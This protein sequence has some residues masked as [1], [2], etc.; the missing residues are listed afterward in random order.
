MFQRWRYTWIGA[1]PIFAENLQSFEQALAPFGLRRGV[2]QPAYG[3]AEAVV[4]VSCNQPATPYRVLAL[5]GSRLREYGHVRVVDANEPGAITLVAN[6]KP[7][8]GAEVCIRQPDGSP[9]DPDQQGHV[10][11][12]GPFVAQSYLGGVE[13]ERFKDGWYDTGDLG[14][15]HD[16]EVYISGR[17]KDVIIRGGVNT[18]P[19][20]VEWVIEQTLGL[21]AAKVVVF[22]RRDLSRAREEVIAVVGMRPA[23]EERAALIRRLSAEVAQAVGLM[24]DQVVFTA[25]AN[26]PKT[27]SGKVQRALAREMYGRGQFDTAV[28]P[29][30]ERLTEETV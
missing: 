21:R 11:I 28:E 16:G 12:A 20:Q 10:W 27:T 18:S 13:P 7:I 2:I 29:A 15:M 30:D 3:L 17:A 23:P 26:I 19:A 24:I 4:A 14:F 6:G 25:A 5:D 22:S 9:A 8:A 1:E